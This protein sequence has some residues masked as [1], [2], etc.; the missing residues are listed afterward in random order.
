MCAE[1]KLEAFVQ[2][3][4]EAHNKG[5]SVS[6]NSSN[7]PNWSFGQSLFFAASVLTTIGKSSYLRI[8]SN[9]IINVWALYTMYTIDIY[10]VY[11]QLW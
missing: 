4:V 11:R 8:Q 10:D 2:A 3:I 1:D 7:E 5:V 6:G 9:N